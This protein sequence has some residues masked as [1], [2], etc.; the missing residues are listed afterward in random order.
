MATRK[1]SIGIFD[2][3]L[4]GLT[5]YR[6]LKAYLPNEH[7]IYLADSNNAP[8]G[9]K[10]Q[11]R[12][13]S[14]SF[15]NA[16]FLIDQGVKLIVVAC[17]TATTAAILQLR[18][19]FHVPFIGIEPALK[20]AALNSAVKKVGVLAT[21]GTLESSLFKQTKAKHGRAIETI[22]VVGKGLVQLIETGKIDSPEMT[23]LLKMYLEPM[24]EAGVDHIVLGCT[25]YPLLKN[26]IQ[27]LTPKEVQII[28]SGLAVAKQTKRILSQEELLLDKPHS[29]KDDVYV[30]GK[31]DIALQ[32]LTQLELSNFLLHQL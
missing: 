21:K 27:A 23:N 14:F 31:T 8:Y 32:I 9:E 30:N 26:K 12:I 29:K 17:N 13:V 16:Q 10:P 4:G 7:F 6:E 22:T 11:Q 18:D 15:L 5:V 3:G 1:G 2:S 24:I 19:S 25:H 28:D 20:P